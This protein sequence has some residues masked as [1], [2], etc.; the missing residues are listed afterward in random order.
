METQ[1]EIRKGKLVDL[2]VVL[3]E[4]VAIVE[5]LD[6]KQE[7]AKLQGEEPILE[8]IEEIRQIENPISLVST[9]RKRGI[10]K[11]SALY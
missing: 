10:T 8:E 1:V 5:K 6:I 11:M 3:K 7:T 4:N 9:V 2:Q